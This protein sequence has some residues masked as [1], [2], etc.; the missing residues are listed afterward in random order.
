MNQME[1]LQQQITRLSKISLNGK[2]ILCHTKT[3]TPRD[4]VVPDVT[5]SAAGHEVAAS[6]PAIICRPSLSRGKQRACFFSGV[7]YGQVNFS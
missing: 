3:P 7:P 1:C 2:E 6:T 5:L 4:R